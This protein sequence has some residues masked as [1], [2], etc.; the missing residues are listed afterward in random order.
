[1]SE[2]KAVLFDLDGTLLDTWDDIVSAINYMLEK[3]GYE[4]RS[5][6]EI[7]SFLGNGARDLVMRSLPFDVDKNTFEAFLEEYKAYY[8]EHSRILTKPYDGVIDVLTALKKRNILT[9]VVSNK[10]DLTVRGLCDQYFEGLIDFSVGDRPDLQRK[11]SADPINFAIDKLGCTKAVYVGDS[12]VD[13]LA[14]SNAKRPC[15]SVT[16]GFRDRDVLEECGASVFADDA[17][18]LL[19]KLY[20]LL[21]EAEI[22]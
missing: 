8:N 11:P 2:I 16:W 21:G 14:A 19:C 7:R 20:E 3:Y 1:M 10:P 13:V 4:K 9:A 6:M 18:E 22:K 15:V 17:D 12:E 5:R